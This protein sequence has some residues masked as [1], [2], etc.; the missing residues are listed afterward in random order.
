MSIRCAQLF[1]GRLA[2]DKSEEGKVEVDVTQCRLL[3]TN[4]SAKRNGRGSAAQDVLTSPIE[5]VE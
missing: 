1:Y 2:Y 5:A 3:K 4:E